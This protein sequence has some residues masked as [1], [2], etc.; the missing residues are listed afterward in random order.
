MYKFDC[1]LPE[2]KNSRAIWNY[3]WTSLTKWATHISYAA[4]ITTFYIFMGILY[5]SPFLNKYNYY[6]LVLYLS[7]VMIRMTS[8]DLLDWYNAVIL[9]TGTKKLYQIY[10]VLALVPAQF[11]GLFHILH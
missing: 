1:C 3:V 6:Y 5:S 7:N 2:L 9:W 11:A 8:G 10:N 4:M